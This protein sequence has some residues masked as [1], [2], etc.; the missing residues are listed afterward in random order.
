[1]VMQLGVK[2]NEKQFILNELKLSLEKK[3]TFSKFHI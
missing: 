2:Q 1:M 3:I